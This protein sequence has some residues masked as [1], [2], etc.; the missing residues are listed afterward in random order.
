MKEKQKRSGLFEG[1]GGLKPIDCDYTVG[2]NRCA[3][4]AGNALFL[5]NAVGGVVAVLIN[6]FANGKD[7][8]GANFYAKRAGFASSVNKLN[9]SFDCDSHVFENSFPCHLSVKQVA[10][11]GQ[12][13][14][15]KLKPSFDKLLATG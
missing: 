1:R 9:S 3:R 12:T 14:Q 15:G 6:A 5:V 7:V 2:T 13:L 4:L 10:L 8:H 11:Q